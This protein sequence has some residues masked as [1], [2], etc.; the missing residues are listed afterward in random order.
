MVPLGACALALMGMGLLTRLELGLRAREGT[1]W[2]AS[3]GRDLAN[4]VALCLTLAG[5]HGLGYSGPVALLLSAALLLAVTAVLATLGE[6]RAPVW[7]ALVVA[8]GAGAPVM[9]LPGHI[10]AW[11]L[12]ALALLS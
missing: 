6:R 1:L 9:A 2:W 4:A 5:L 12:R 10:Q 3:N 11:V 7:V 8:L